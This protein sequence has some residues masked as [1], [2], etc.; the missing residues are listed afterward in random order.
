[1]KYISEGRIKLN[2][3]DRGQLTRNPPVSAAERTVRNGTEARYLRN[4]SIQL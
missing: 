2:A 3:R 4:A 1:M